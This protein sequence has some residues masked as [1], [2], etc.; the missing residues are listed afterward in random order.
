MGHQANAVNFVYMPIE[1]Y[2]DKKQIYSEM[3]SA[4]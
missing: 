2:D 1:D 4:D 3:R